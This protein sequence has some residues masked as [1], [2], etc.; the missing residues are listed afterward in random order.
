[1]KKNY[2]FYIENGVLFIKGFHKDFGCMTSIEVTPND[3][4]YTEGMLEIRRQKAE[5]TRRI[6]YPGIKGHFELIS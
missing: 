2:S 1:M 6:I 4:L 3:P 5:K